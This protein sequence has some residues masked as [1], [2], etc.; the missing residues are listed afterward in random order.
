MDFQQADEQFKQL[1]ARFTA[2]ELTE[3]EFK[4]QLQ[5]LMVAG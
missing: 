5:D 3:A 4:A 2:G 1:K